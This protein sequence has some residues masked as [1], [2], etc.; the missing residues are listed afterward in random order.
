M[1][2]FMLVLLALAA[3]LCSCGEEKPKE[4]DIYNY[5]KTLEDLDKYIIVGNYTG[6]T[7]ETVTVTD[8]DV[9][10]RV[11]K[12]QDEHSYYKKIDKTEVEALDNVHISYVS[13]LDG[14]AFDGGRGED[15]LV[16]GNGEYE[17][18][19][20]EIQL[21]GA[22]VNEKRSIKVTIPDDYY[23]IGLRGKTIT[24]EVTVTQIQESEKT[25]PELTDA[26]VKEK[27]KKNTVAEFKQYVKEQL[28]KEAEEKMLTSAWKAALANCEIIDYPEGLVEEYVATMKKHYT[29]EAK[30][31]G[32]TLE[33]AVG[34]V[35]E[36]EKEATQYAMDYYKSE[37]AMYYILDKEFGRDISNKE[38]RTRV[39]AYAEE[40]GVTVEE[41]EKKYTKDELVTSMQW[42]KVMEFIWDK[43]VKI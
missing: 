1:K 25:V 10:A 28:D 39:I 6:V 18:R 32:S 22:K 23:S 41:L 29:D 36:W 17:F 3:V 19:E 27:F 11:A 12:L 13:Y 7:V 20:V 37:I 4:R 21:V 5:I 34:D 16:V 26:F 2:R 43:A 30:K 35:A 42:D 15:D 40:Q 38:Y 8:K 31:Y 9:E 33:Y 14:E 24:M